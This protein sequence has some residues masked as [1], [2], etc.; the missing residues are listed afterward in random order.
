[1][2]RAAHLRKADFRTD[3]WKRVR[4]EIE[5]ELA[6][7]RERLESFENTEAS[8]AQLRGKIAA[9]KNMLA[10]EKAP[11]ADPR[12]AGTRVDDDG[13]EDGVPVEGF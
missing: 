4:L 3:A 10:L 9:L 7:A 6:K 8:T 5:A 13:P 1:M 12:Q 2:A 11:A